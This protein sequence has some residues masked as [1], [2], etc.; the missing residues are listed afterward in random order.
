MSLVFEYENK[1]VDV[2]NDSDDDIDADHDL[3]GNSCTQVSTID[4]H[5]EIDLVDVN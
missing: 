3:F 4:V 5:V 1:I 2:I